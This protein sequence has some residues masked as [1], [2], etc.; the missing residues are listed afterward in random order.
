MLHLVSR[1][2]ERG[3]ATRPLPPPIGLESS[4]RLFDHLAQREQGLLV[5]GPADELKAERRALYVAPRRDSDAR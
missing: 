3:R 4:G 2:I 1:L 5:E